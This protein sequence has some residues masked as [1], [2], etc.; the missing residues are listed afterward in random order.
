[1]QG[2][3]GLAEDTGSPGSNES[4]ASRAPGEL[5]AAKLRPPRTDALPRE[6][7]DDLLGGLWSRRFALVVAP[8]GSGK[9][10]LLARFAATAGVPVG[11]YRPETWDGAVEVFL[12]YLEAALRSALGP[13]PGDWRTVEDAA[14]ALQTW[15][16]SRALLVVDDL[17]T[18]EGTPAEAALERL[19][20]YVPSLHLLAASRVQPRFNLPRLRVSGALLEIGGDDLRFRSWEVE[21]L[22]RDYY[23]APLPPVE[24]ATLARRTEGWAAGLQLFHLATRGKAPAERRRVLAGL[25][26]GSRF[27]RE[28]L[29]RNVLEELPAE[30]RGFLVDTCVLQRLSGPI[31]D[32]FLERRDSRALLRELERRQVFTQALDDDG[33]YR[34]HEVLRTHLE[35]ILV[36]EQGEEAVRGRHQRAAAVLEAAGAVAEALHAHCRAEDWVAV[37]RLIGHR[38][39]ELLQGP[40]AWMDAL[41]PALLAHD[42]W[43]LLAGAR[44]QRADGLWEAALASYQRAEQALSAP[45]AAEAARRERQGLAAWV[46]TGVAPGSDALGLLRAATQRDPL[47]VRRRAGLAGPESADLVAGLCLLLAGEVREARRVLGNAAAAPLA[48]GAQAVSASLALGAADLLAGDPHG[49]VE[50]GHAIEAAEA[51]GLGFLTRLGHAC[52]A[53][54]PGGAA[55]A[56]AARL[57]SER[58]GDAWGVALAG[59]LEGLSRAHAADGAELAAAAELLDSAADRFEQLEAPVLQA[60][61]AAA[62]ALALAR[63]GAPDAAGAARRAERLA[64]SRGAGGA[65]LFTDAALAGTDV[66]RRS[67]HQ[68]LA[69]ARRFSSGIGPDWAP[70]A[71]VRPPVSIRLFGGF[72][73]EMNGT[74][75]DLSGLKPR[76]RALLRLL[77]VQGGRPLHREAIQVALWPEAATDAAGRNL[78]VAISSLR[79]ALE[80]GV[81]RAGFT[82]VVRDG[83]AYRLATG[84]DVS[85]DLVAFESDMGQGR[86]GAAAGDAGRALAGFCS[87]LDRY[88]GELLPE[89]GASDWVVDHRERCRSAAAEAAQWV[90]EHRLRGGDPAGAA[91]AAAGGLRIDRYH[92][93]LWRLL[94]TA[95]EQAGDHVAASR[96]RA[97]Y[98][99]VL[100][101]LGLDSAR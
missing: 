62:R 63:S 90:A 44:R 52:R 12:G 58:V 55:V 97:E 84:A 67:E 7:L 8:A 101:E 17:H 98:A 89:D 99:Q 81:A 15:P 71:P 13:L 74:V 96:A 38:G 47:G 11:W 73:L 22:F 50:L 65:V 9:T 41:P 34:Y 28:Y 64:Q 49:A 29:T 6:R 85:V 32:A 66:S 61:A 10:T 43:L 37:E 86:S 23:Q 26:S 94:A 60:W 2:A 24:L 70:V 75:V 77:A 18:L 82:L 53:L 56:A 36:Q 3:N 40:Q 91:Q 4:G 68:A 30:L 14:R 20:D 72:Q 16:G 5:L 46:Q 78:H 45:N 25:S 92:D 35:S 79:Q 83:D 1:M 19:I 76:V 57:S 93:P 87:A 48:S 51:Q 27:V 59:L 39:E 95:R 100:A 88:A 21:R 69:S 80:P 54:E 31:C 33:Q 42:P